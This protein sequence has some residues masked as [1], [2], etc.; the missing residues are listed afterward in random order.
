MFSRSGVGAG[1]CRRGVVRRL[2]VERRPAAVAAPSPAHRPSAP[3]SAEGRSDGAQADAMYSNPARHPAHPAH[4]PH[5]PH[6]QQP[7]NFRRVG[8][9]CSVCF[10]VVGVTFSKCGVRLSKTRT[11]PPSA[12][13][14]PRNRQTSLSPRRPFVLS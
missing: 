3:P 11:T 14:S 9:F 2:T 7:V 12:I 8:A 13:A 4:P 10:A 5:P 6:P 1:R